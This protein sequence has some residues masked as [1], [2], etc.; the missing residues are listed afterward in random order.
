MSVALDGDVAFPIRPPDPCP[1][2]TQP[3]QRLRGGVAIA[4]APHADHRDLRPDFGQ[5][6]SRRCRPRP[7]VTHLQHIGRAERSGQRRLGHHP[8]IAH[9]QGPKRAPTDLED[10]RVLVEV[11]PGV[12]PCG[13]RVEHS[14]AHAIEMPLVTS[15]D[16]TP[17]DAAGGE[18]LKPGVVGRLHECLAGLQRHTEWQCR[19]DGGRAADMIAVGMRQHHRLDPSGAQAAEQREHHPLACIPA[20]IG[21][22]GVHHHPT[23]CRGPDQ[24]RI[25]LTDIHEN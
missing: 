11:V 13:G 19:S 14:E 25:A 21:R 2:G 7:V 15:R 12:R 17:S 4:I 10:G 9:Q 3:G 20:F 6:Y 22:S 23:T 24:G 5:K 18:R 1:D 8:R 16:C